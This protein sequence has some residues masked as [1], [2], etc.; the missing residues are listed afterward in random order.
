[1][2]LKCVKELTHYF[3]FIIV[4]MTSALI[5]MNLNHNCNTLSIESLEFYMNKRKTSEENQLILLIYNYLLKF[6]YYLFK[7]YS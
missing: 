2:F 5:W 1:M 7:V 6:R 3:S 4:L